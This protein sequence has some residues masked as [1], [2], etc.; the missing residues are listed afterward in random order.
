MNPPSFLRV[1]TENA[2]GVLNHTDLFDGTLTF[3]STRYELTNS[4]YKTLFEA[5]EAAAA[6]GGVLQFP[7]DENS[8]MHGTHVSEIADA[9]LADAEAPREVVTGQ[10]YNISGRRYE[11]LREIGDALAAEYDGVQEVR[12]TPGAKFVESADF[13]GKGFLMSVTEFSQWVGSEKLRTETGWKTVLRGGV[14][15]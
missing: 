14:N 6:E 13:L 4:H 10:G 15:L 1:R 7:A 9:C 12:Y 8:I 2:V 11:T 3:P 5:A